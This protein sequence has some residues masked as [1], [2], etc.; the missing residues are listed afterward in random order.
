VK[1]KFFLTLSCAALIA[2]S[3]RADERPMDHGSAPATALAATPAEVNVESV[4]QKYKKLHADTIKMLKESAQTL[5]RLQKEG[6]SPPT[7]ILSVAL[8]SELLRLKKEEALIKAFEDGTLKK[9]DYVTLMAEGSFVLEN[10]K[11]FGAFTKAAY[12]TWEKRDRALNEK[13]VMLLAATLFD[14]YYTAEDG[15]AAVYNDVELRDLAK[16]GRTT[17]D[18]FKAITSD[19]IVERTLYRAKFFP[20]YA[21]NLITKNEALI[22]ENAKPKAP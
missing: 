4:F 1:L 6:N 3:A 17:L 16:N 2:V 9:D 8:A 22:L 19:D 21:A 5:Q 18:R 12:E 10:L 7:L 11:M 20:G 14:D 15:K 13:E